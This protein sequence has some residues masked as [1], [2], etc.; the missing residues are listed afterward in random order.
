MT[1][2]DVIEA[3][4]LA[5]PDEAEGG[6]SE[7]GEE[8]I[9]LGSDE[10]EE[11]DYFPPRTA[12]PMVVGGVCARSPNPAVSLDLHEAC[13]RAAAR[14]NISYDCVPTSLKSRHCNFCK[15]LYVGLSQKH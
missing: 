4:L 5:E 11:D 12:S 8:S 1:Q 9:S 13:K 10:D 7:S 15:S 6:Y 2:P 14:L 3:S